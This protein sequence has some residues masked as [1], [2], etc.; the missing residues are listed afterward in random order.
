MVKTHS[1]TVKVIKDGRVTIPRQIREVEGINEGDFLKIT[2]EK[3]QKPAN[4]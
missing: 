1:A 2:I 4:S 3:I